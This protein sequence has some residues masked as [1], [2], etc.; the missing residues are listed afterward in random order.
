MRLDDERLGHGRASRRRGWCHEKTFACFH[1]EARKA[2]L[3]GSGD[4]R[5]WDL[6]MRGSGMGEHQEGGDA[7]GAMRKR[8][9]S[10]RGKPTSAAM[11]IREDETW[12]CAYFNFRINQIRILRTTELIERSYRWVLRRFRHPVVASPWRSAGC[13]SIRVKRKKKIFFLWESRTYKV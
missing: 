7:S 4:K 2:D 1:I 8:C 5:R 6:T 3:S 10:R 9:M 12:A 11:S 13:S